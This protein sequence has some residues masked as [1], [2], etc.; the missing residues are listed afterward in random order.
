MMAIVKS[1]QKHL[2]N[3]H[4]IIDYADNFCNLFAM[5]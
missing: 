3:I 2:M 1:L 4:K 5:K